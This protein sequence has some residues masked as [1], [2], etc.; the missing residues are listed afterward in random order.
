MLPLLPAAMGKLHRPVPFGL[1][2]LLLFPLTAYPVFRILMANTHLLRRYLLWPSYYHTVSVS[3]AIF[4]YGQPFSLWHSVMSL[5]LLGP[6]TVP[7]GCAGLRL[8][9]ASRLFLGMIMNP[10]LARLS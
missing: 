8:K 10:A 7:S 4:L 6:P 5:G 2:S 1:G 9:D 3:S